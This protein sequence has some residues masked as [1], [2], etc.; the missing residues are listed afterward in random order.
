VQFVIS[1]L[2]VGVLGAQAVAAPTWANVPEL[3]AS[4]Q[5]PVADE[6]RACVSGK[7]PKTISVILVRG[8]LRTTAALPL[9]GVGIRGVSPE[10]RCLGAAVA[11]LAFPE[12]P[13]EIVQ[14]LLGVTIRRGATALPAPDKAFDDWKD[15]ATAVASLIDGPRRATLAACDVKARTVRVIVDRTARA[16]RVWLPAWQFHSPNGDGTTPP[17]E[18]R[19][20]AC[21][22]KVLRA[23]RAPA[24]PAALG[25]LQLAIRVSR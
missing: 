3:I 19:V 4:T 7:L 20:K 5:D 23:W 25:E 1:A 10:Q 14:V 22:T 18:Q 21:M 17:A 13:A 16:T 24:L 9:Y 12:L 8:K 6:L 2:V 15:P 11:K